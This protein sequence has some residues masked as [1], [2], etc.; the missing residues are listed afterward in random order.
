MN[1][2]PVNRSLRPLARRRP[3]LHIH[4]RPAAFAGAPV[5]H[6][7]PWPVLLLICTRLGNPH[8]PLDCSRAGQNAILAAYHHGLGSC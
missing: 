2:R 6:V 3:V 1:A 8:T 7:R 4:Q 5:R